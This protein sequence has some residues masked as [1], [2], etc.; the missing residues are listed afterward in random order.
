MVEHFLGKEEVRRS[1]RLMSTIVVKGQYIY[2]MRAFAGV[3][4]F[5]E[6]SI[7]SPDFVVFVVKWL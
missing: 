1:N 6:I 7:L 4:G 2:F 5:G 3:Y